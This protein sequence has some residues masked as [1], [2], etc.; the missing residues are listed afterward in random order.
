MNRLHFNSF[1]NVEFSSNS[2][3]YRN[4]KYAQLLRGVLEIGQ[5]VF[6]G[7]CMCKKTFIK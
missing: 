4:A 5:L 2:I 3:G 7:V 1:V 6:T